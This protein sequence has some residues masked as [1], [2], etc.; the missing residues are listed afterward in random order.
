ME[1]R[2]GGRERSGN[3]V[4]EREGCGDGDPTDAEVAECQV[5]VPDCGDE[6][7]G[8]AR[9]GLE[10]IV[11]NGDGGDPG[12]RVEGD[13]VEVE[14]A[15]SDGAVGCDGWD[16]GVWDGEEERGVGVGKGACEGWVWVE[17][18]EGG[19]FEGRESDG[20]LVRWLFGV[21]LGGGGGGGSAVSD[22][23]GGG[24]RGG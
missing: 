19:E 9:G 1:F 21:G 18:T 3:D 5:Y 2:G 16:Q 13:Y 8:V 6:E 4:D 11:A 17:D 10:E 7:G 15:E 14:P 20:Y 23:E 22:A 12:A 24:K